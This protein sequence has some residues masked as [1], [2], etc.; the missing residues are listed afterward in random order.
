M[1]IRMLSWFELQTM[2]WAPGTALVAYYA[3]AKRCCCPAGVT[4]DTASSCSGNQQH[5]VF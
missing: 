5:P 1:D 2:C 3:M 4:H